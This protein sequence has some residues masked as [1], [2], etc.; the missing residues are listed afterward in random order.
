MS[1][2]GKILKVDLTDGSI[3]KIPTSRYARDFIGGPA[4]GAKLIYDHVS[5]SVRGKDP[6]NMITFNTGPLTGTLLG[7][8]WNIMAKSPKMTNSTLVTAGMGG[9]LPAELKFA[10]YD[11]LAVTGKAD[12]PVYLF[13][14]NDKVEIKDAR[15]LWGLDTEEV[16][17]RIK[18]ELKDPDVQIACIGPGGENGFVGALIIH[19]IQNSAS[20]GG[21]GAVMGSKNLKA[22]AVRGMK[23]LKIADRE[24]F[25]SL[26]NEY[27]EA[28]STG[29]TRAYV[30]I[31]HTESLSTHADEYHLKGMAQW[32]YGP[33]ASFISPEMTKEELMG[34]FDRKYRVGSI[35]CAFCPIQ[36]KANYD[37]PGMSS[38]GA[39]CFTYL[40][41]RAPVKNLDTKL[42]FKSFDKLQRYGL[43]MN[44]ITGMAG[45]LMLLYQEG[46]ITAADTDGVPMEWGSETAIMTIIE[47]I[48]KGEGFGKHFTDGIVPAAKAI[49]DGNGFFLACQDRNFSIPL[50]L[51]ERGVTLTGPGAT[52]MV[53]L[54]TEFIWYHP[55]Y[56]RHGVYDLFAPIFGLTSQE[57]LALTDQWLSEF[58]E[59]HTG[60]PGAWKPEVI[61]GKAEYVAATENIISASDL[62]GNCDGSTART[63]HTGCV[64]DVDHVARAIAAATGESCTVDRLL[65]TVQRRRLL[66]LSYNLL[67]ERMV[68]DMADISPALMRTN[69]E[70]VPDGPF[71]GQ[72][73]DL[74]G[75]IKA[76]EEYCTLRGVNPDTGVPTREALEKVGLKDVADRLEGPGVSTQGPSTISNAGTC[77]M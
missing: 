24:A 69:I 2:A 53:Q 57:T 44:E 32:G 66:E 15:H 72:A 23:G 40:C 37:V 34:E 38:G 51:P 76:G 68:G 21:L 39:N 35:G 26:W 25:L 63:P 75:S 18:E 22:V 8:K 36:C 11:N 19:E 5:P 42:W 77:P 17:V 52:K 60:N 54:A 71:K 48:A 20:Q 31:S 73:W 67:C 61:E 30:K 9:Q 33:D 47:K 46:I 6:E 64:W 41:M 55:P 49:A 1:R 13:I 27:W 4:V 45:W 3:E 43:D 28:L 12:K 58:A 16:Q 50:M 70:P 56:D 14:T 62:A 10:G 74:E 65:E 29:R 59:K 7:T